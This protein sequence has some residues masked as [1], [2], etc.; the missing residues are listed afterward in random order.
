MGS[1][2]VIVAA[3]VGDTGRVAVVALGVAGG[4]GG[5]A[6]DGEWLGDVAP[7]VRTLD[8]VG[9]IDVGGAGVDRLPGLGGHHGV[10]D[11]DL[12]ARDE[13]VVGRRVEIEVGSLV[14]ER[15]LRELLHGAHLRV[16]RRVAG[17][18]LTARCLGLGVEDHVV[19]GLELTDLVG[20]NL[21]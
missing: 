10:G 9:E 21:V 6:V 20:V 7:P 8:R 4:P 12:L 17:L 18:H 3:V 5:L 14:D 13:S 15:L 19:H 16:A 11:D 1:A 2:G